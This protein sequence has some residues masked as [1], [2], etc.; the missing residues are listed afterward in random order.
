MNDLLKMIDK[1]FKRRLS[2][3]LFEKAR[4]FP[5]DPVLKDMRRY[6]GNPSYS[7]VHIEVKL[8]SASSLLCLKPGM[9]ST[10]GVLS[11][12]PPQLR[13]FSTLTL[14]PP[15]LREKI[16]KPNGFLLNHTRERFY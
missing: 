2:A 1:M 5:R 12:A 6:M 7:Y 14:A 9:I 4:E 15:Q 16:E 13:M 3:Y 11:L 8:A 10:L